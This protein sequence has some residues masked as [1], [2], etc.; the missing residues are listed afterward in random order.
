MNKPLLDRLRFEGLNLAPPQTFGPIRLLPVINPSPRDDIRLGLEGYDAYGIVTVDGMP[1]KPKKQYWSYIP[2]G[3]VVTW[4]KDGESAVPFGADLRKNTATPAPPVKLHHRMAKRTGVDEMRILPLHLAME[5]FLSLHFGGPPIAW[6]NY[7]KHTKDFG[8]SPRWEFA[9]RAGLIDGLAESMRL[10]E[11]HENQVGVLV[12]VADALASAFVVSHP[13][14]YRRLH[15]SVL[16][17]FFGEVFIHYSNHAQIGSLD[18]ALDSD[19]VTSLDKLATACD[20]V[21]TQWHEQAD[22]LVA[23]LADRPLESTVVN[24]LGHFQ[25]ERFMTDL[26]DEREAH[27]GEAIVHQN[28]AL[29]YL[30]TYRLSKNQIKRAH[31]LKM[32]AAHDWNID[33]LAAAEGDT[34]D[35][36]IKRMHNVGF[37]YLLNPEVLAKA[38]RP[39]YL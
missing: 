9:A 15:T 5:G 35:A 31:L 2:H 18:I 32:L 4:G 33:A 14:D 26:G 30:K 7:S 12:F 23:G 8:L 27:I 16:Q 1:H 11:I 29:Q 17:D 25:L 38:T 36:V 22:I 39:T 28:G 20:E 24:S 13:E 21:F 3:L 34:P 6:S 10:F 19:G 37:G